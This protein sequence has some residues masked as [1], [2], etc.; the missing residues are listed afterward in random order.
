[1]NNWIFVKITGK[2]SS[3]FKMIKSHYNSKSRILN[4]CLCK[5]LTA[6]VSENNDSEVVCCHNSN[7]GSEV[8]RALVY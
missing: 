8:S 6:K 3:S 1:M 7:I 2:N 4:A 5:T